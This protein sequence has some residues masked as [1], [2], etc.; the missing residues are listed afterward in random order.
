MDKLKRV[1]IQVLIVAILY[2]NVAA[3]LIVAGVRLPRAPSLEYTSGPLPNHWVTERLFR[4]FD[5][6]DRWSWTNWEVS[7]WGTRDEVEPPP[8]QPTPDMV[9]LRLYTWFPQSQGEAIRR[10]WLMSYRNNE[11]RLRR[12]YAVMARTL[13]RLYNEQHPGEPVAQ[14]FFYEHTWR[15]SDQ[16]FYHLFHERQTTRIESE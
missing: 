1:A 3:M 14:V 10:F 15:K 7:A 8:A 6:F 2:F 12:E 11:G 5:V 4:T 16:G 13:K 9:N